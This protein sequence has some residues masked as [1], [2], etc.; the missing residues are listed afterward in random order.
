MI[1]KGVF[2]GGY[3]VPQDRE[4]YEIRNPADYRQVVSKFPMLRRSDV[5]EAIKVAKETFEKWRE[6]T[7]YERAKILFKTAEVLESRSEEVVKTIT[8]EEG[9]TLPESRYEV[10]RIV[11]LLRFYGGLILNSLGR[12]IPSG[13]KNSFTLTMR[14]PLG[15]VG[16]ITPWNFPF[17]L[18]SWK[19]IPA[20][21]TGNTV[22]LKPASITP[23]SAL[24][25]VKAFHDAG[26][27]P[28]VI[29]MVTGS[30]KEV[31]DEIVTNKDVSAISFTGSL[32]VGKEIN[33][34]VG[35][36]F[37]RV[38]LELGGKNATVLT[39]KGD[40][41]MAIKHVTASTVRNAGQ[42]CLATSRFLVPKK[43]H[44]KVLDALT[45]RFKKVVVG[46]GMKQG[47]E[48]GP[49]SSREQYE[50]VLNYIEIGK[51]EGARLVYGGE[52]VKGSDEYDYG[53]FIRP[54]IFDKVT[55][56]MRIA[57]EEI[58]G[59][60]LS[61]MEY[62]DLDE[63]IEIVNSTEY[64][65]TAEIISND[66]SE[67][68][69]FSQKVEVGNVK[70]NR[71]TIE[72]DQWVPYGGFKGSGNDIYKELGEEAIQFYTRTKVVYFHYP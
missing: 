5:I 55:E 65:L 31:G 12:T 9:K 38:Q 56:D 72:L 13:T 29:N 3:V 30:G 53:Y 10:E 35:N 54:T 61:V 41:D 69:E 27:P 36:R 14:E 19:V 66:I 37:V 63:A 40:I 60:V 33:G 21:A 22:V 7:V 15:V 25:I 58:F 46:N 6:T 28:G 1:E 71:P 24:E 64:G 59:P 8:L 70:V 43:L 51:S 18:P 49:V 26:V 20:I 48:M 44:D 39:D 67:V 68:M 47:V 50:K 4:F 62:E 23:N 34:R 52:P 17:L 32:E 42:I 11:V 45:E 2:I 16:L 57:K